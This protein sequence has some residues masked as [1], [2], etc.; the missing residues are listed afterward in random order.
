MLL[1]MLA[2]SLGSAAPLPEITLV[3]L[4]RGDYRFE[5]ARFER[6][7]AD[8][9]QNALETR[10]TAQCG[11]LKVRWGKFSYETAPGMGAESG[12]EYVVGYQQRFRCY[13]PATDPYKPV[14]SDW[15][16]SAEDDR[17]AQAFTRKF[18]GLFASD[19][20][21]MAKPMFDPELELNQT[22]WTRQR[23]QM[24]KAGP[25]SVDLDSIG[26]AANPEG[27]SHPGAFA[28]IDF[29]GE[30]RDLALMCGWIVL[31]RKGPDRYEITQMQTYII[32]N[33]DTA[34]IASY[35]GRANLKS[36]CTR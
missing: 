4:G 26:W 10:A 25:G 1:S 11:R 28:R 5:V 32:P 3:P 23:G 18:L 30:Y 12:L 14:P 24:S 6:G 19:G 8:Q 15:Q 31:Y 34:A 36:V 20:F 13:D 2:L 27:M 22:M 7:L 9:V 17:Q 16:P 29:S 35:G 33:S 21:Q